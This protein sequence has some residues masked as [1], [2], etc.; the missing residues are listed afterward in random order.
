ML[1]KSV[2]T[3]FSKTLRFI[4]TNTPIQLIANYQPNMANSPI[5]GIKPTVMIFFSTIIL[6][7]F[8]LVL[9]SEL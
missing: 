9:W 1:S 8:G 5:K 2:R 4:F 3:F 6:F 7:F